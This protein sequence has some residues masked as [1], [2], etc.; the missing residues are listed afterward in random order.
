MNAVVD[1]SETN[2]LSNGGLKTVLEY[3]RNTT[4]EWLKNIHLATSLI[5]TTHLECAPLNEMK[6][7]KVFLYDLLMSSRRN[8]MD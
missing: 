1:D 3:T 5:N 4:F 2:K 8:K 7:N 6:R